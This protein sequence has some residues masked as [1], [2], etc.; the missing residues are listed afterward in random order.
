SGGRVNYT[1]AV[2]NPTVLTGST[3]QTY[4]LN[5]APKDLVY[6]GIANAFS[7][8]NSWKRNGATVAFGTVTPGR[9]ETGYVAGSAGGS[10]FVLAPTE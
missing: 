8:S 2:V 1:D 10:L 5:N 3:G 9:T 6:T 7:N 4:S